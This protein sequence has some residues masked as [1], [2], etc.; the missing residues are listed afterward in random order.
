MAAS[1]LDSVTLQYWTPILSN[2]K[3]VVMQMSELSRAGGVPV[4]TVKYYLR[5][6]L[7][8]PGVS[9]SATRATY[10]DSHV[11]RLRL[12]RALAEVGNLKLDTIRD[13]LEAVDAGENLHDTVGVAHS[14][15]APRGAASDSAHAAVDRLLRR[16]RWRV[17]DGSANREALAV[18]F[19]ALERVGYALPESALDVYAGAAAAVAEVDVD[20]VPT[21]AAEDAVQHVVVGTV[22]LEPVL[23]ALRR[24]AQEHLSRRRLARH[25]RSTVRTTRRT[26]G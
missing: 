16:R 17:H 9:T 15:L 4:A 3:V 8:A 21:D 25:P 22:L 6:G 26:R 13:I 14:A 24:L 23:L 19:D 1:R 10:D 11:R 20:S 12:V 7:L 18:A 2:V 5:E